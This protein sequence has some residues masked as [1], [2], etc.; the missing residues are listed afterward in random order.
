MYIFFSSA[1][2]TLYKTER[3]KKIKLNNQV[4]NEL[5]AVSPPLS[6]FSL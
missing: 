2:F 5:F 4:T 1:N 3:V 6:S